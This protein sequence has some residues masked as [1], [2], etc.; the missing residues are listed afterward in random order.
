[1]PSF[2]AI[3]LTVKNSFP[4]TSITQFIGRYAGAHNKY[5]RRVEIVNAY[6]PETLKNLEIIPRRYKYILI[7]IPSGYIIKS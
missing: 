4:F 7:N 2:S 6:L 1:M 5:T 3:S